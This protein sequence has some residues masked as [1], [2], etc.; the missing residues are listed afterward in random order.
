MQL[1]ENAVQSKSDMSL[2]SL[3]STWK[4]L[5]ADL[6][7]QVGSM[8]VITDTKDKAPSILPTGNWIQISGITG[9]G[10]FAIYVPAGFCKD[11]LNAGAA[12]LKIEELEGADAALLFEHFLGE[13][14]AQLENLLGDEIHLTKVVDVSTPVSGDL[15]GL[16]FD[17][18]S[19]KHQGALQVSGSLHNWLE[20][21]VGQHS[22]AEEKS[23]DPTMIVHLGP[24]VVPSRQAYLAGTGATIDCGVMPSD[25]IK[26][27]LLR[28]DNRYWPIYI[29]DNAVQI[30]GD[31]VGPVDPNANTSDD[32]VFVTF[33]IGQ[34]SLKPF[35][36]AKLQVGTQLSIDRYPDNGA[37]VYFQG[38]PYGKGQITLLGDN[39]GVK[40]N[41]IG[42]FF[43]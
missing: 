29:E 42:G 9:K 36:R 1:P 22:S 7:F 39:L 34:V 13:R 12:D 25:I 32:H 27:V 28:S 10:D 33:G 6:T 16:E 11:L 38:S 15:L 3:R 37:H 35:E 40:V 8:R 19:N 26:G 41:T 21:A 2:L 24:V 43:D 14:I 30:V 18:G 23:L 31:L 5:I 20:Y 4:G 17:T